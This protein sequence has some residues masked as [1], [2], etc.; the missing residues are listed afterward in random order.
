VLNMY[1]LFEDDYK[2]FVFGELTELWILTT[3]RKSRIDVME[4]IT[5]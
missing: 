5:S 3:N 2:E 4:F 1:D